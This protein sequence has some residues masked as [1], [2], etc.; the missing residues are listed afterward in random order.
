MTKG[1]LVEVEWLD[2]SIDTGDLPLEPLDYDPSSQDSRSV[3]YFVKQGLVN[4]IIATD[5][6]PDAKEPFRTA[7]RIP[8]VLIRGIRILSP[9][10][11]KTLHRKN[12]KWYVS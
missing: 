8:L 3:G 7:Q 12:G 9:G 2:A 6:Y 4:L 11:R 1:T 10:K 5:Y